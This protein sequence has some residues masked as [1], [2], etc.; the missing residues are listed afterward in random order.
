MRKE[1]TAIVEIPA[2]PPLAPHDP[3]DPVPQATAWRRALA[4]VE[5]LTRPQWPRSIG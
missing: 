1:L 5:R 2:T 4:V 3:P